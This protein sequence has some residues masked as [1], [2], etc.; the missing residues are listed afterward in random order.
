MRCK[1]CK[2]EGSPIQVILQRLDEVESIT[3]L[4]ACVGYKYEEH[5]TIPEHPFILFS[6]HSWKQLENLFQKV[7]THLTVPTS[8]TYN[9]SK[10]FMFEINLP[11]AWPNRDKYLASVWVEVT[12][13]VEKHV[14]PKEGPK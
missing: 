9:G 2:Q 6:V 13:R 10:Q 5:H 3:V 11:T 4:S 7:F 1:K 8:L 12:E 14:L